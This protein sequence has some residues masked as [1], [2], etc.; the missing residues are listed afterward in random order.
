MCQ[1]YSCILRIHWPLVEKL[2]AQITDPMALPQKWDCGCSWFEIDVWCTCQATGWVSM[3]APPSTMVVWLTWNTSKAVTN[4]T[5]GSGCTCLTIP[6][7]V[8]EFFSQD[9]VVYRNCIQSNLLVNVHD[10]LCSK[11]PGWLAKRNKYWSN[12]A[13]GFGRLQRTGHWGICR[14]LVCICGNAPLVQGASLQLSWHHKAL[15][16]LPKRTRVWWSGSRCLYL[17]YLCF[18]C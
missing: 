8:N 5:M 15:L 10:R 2:V 7:P 13:W 6:L 12:D 9:L 3:K 1:T 17:F 16:W 4:H 11:L 14:Q 18:I